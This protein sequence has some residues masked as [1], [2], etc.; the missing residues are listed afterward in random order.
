MS[1]LGDDRLEGEIS[2]FSG[3]VNK[4]LLEIDELNVSFVFFIQKKKKHQASLFTITLSEIATIQMLKSY[5]INK[6]LVL[7]FA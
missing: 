4:R 7:G 3:T 2:R 6:L 5:E 1:F